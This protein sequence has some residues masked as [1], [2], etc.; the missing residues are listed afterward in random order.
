VLLLLHLEYSSIFELPG[1][2][3]CIRRG[4]FDELAGGQLGPPLGEFLELDLVPDIGQ[5][6]LDLKRLVKN[7]SHYWVLRLTT[8]LSRTL[9]AVGMDDMAEIKSSVVLEMMV[10]LRVLE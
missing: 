2:D 8:E 7:Y 6:G 9:A 10:R 5:R 4:T 1:D 3:V